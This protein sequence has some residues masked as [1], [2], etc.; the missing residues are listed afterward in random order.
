MSTLVTSEPT[1]LNDQPVPTWFGVGGRAKRL[2]RVRSVEQLRACLAIDPA[3]RILGDGANLLVGDAGVDELVVVLGE[4]GEAGELNSWR[5]TDHGAHANV[6]VG[7]GA[8]LPKLI[9]EM[10]RQGL[11]GLEVLG[12]IPAS[13]GGAVM[14]NAGGAFGEIGSVVASVTTL[15]RPSAQ[16]PEVREVVFARRQIT[17]GYRSTLLGTDGPRGP[18]GAVRDAIIT[19]VELRLKKGT[20]EALRAKLK[21]VMEYKKKTQPLA[22][23]SAGCTFKNPVLSADLPGIA[24]AGTKVSAGLLIDRAG[25]KGLRVGGAEVSSTHANFFACHPG[26]T[27]GDVLGLM[28]LVRQRVRES[29]GVELQPEVAIWGERL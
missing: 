4:P 2:A 25:C 12:G 21:E 20:P 3:L 6:V 13:V 15:S 22:E 24:V 8:N 18:A 9:N 16:E 19:S 14:M 1:I 27:A 28:R 10:V 26:A 17:F 5:V 29:F 11:S 7:A 23:R